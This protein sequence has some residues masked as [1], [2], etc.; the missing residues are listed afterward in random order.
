MEPLQ[1]IVGL[2]NPGPS[3]Q[4]TRHN[5]GFWLLDALSLR[6]GANLRPQRRM[7]GA[8]AAATI[9][10]RKVWLL[11]PDTYVNRSGEAVAALVNYY[12]IP[13]SALL[14]AYDELDLIPGVVRFKSGGGHAGHNGLRDIIARLGGSDFQRLRIGIG[15][16]GTKDQVVGYVLGRPSGPERDAILD[17]IAVALEEIEALVGPEREA[18]IMRL[19]TATR[20][21][22]PDPDS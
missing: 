15:H 17:G 18:A 3:Y 2:G 1:A 22:R 11:R 12:K 19:H 16:P 5:A 10:G 8:L 21:P 6:L 20:P 4:E 13:P 7:R 14:V 9:G